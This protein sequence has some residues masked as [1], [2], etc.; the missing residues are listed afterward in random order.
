MGATQQELFN[1]TQEKQ[2]L[3]F[4]LKSLR[5]A[6][7]AEFFNILQNDHFVEVYMGERQVYR[8]FNYYSLCSYSLD[9]LENTPWEQLFTREDPSVVECIIKEI[10]LALNERQIVHSKVPEHL[11]IETASPLRNE[12]LYKLKAIVPL[13]DLTHNAQD[14]F[15]TVISAKLVNTPIEV[16]RQ[17]ILEEHELNRLRQKTAL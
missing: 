17:R 15:L 5:L 9:V 6:P 16:I 3:W 2:L 1:S 8:T 14:C 12:I 4:A 10:K 7:P 13:N 11:V